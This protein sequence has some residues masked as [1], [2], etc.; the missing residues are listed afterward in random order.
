MIEEKEALLTQL[1]MCVDTDGF[2]NIQS[3][4][5]HGC[6]QHFG[7]VNTNTKLMEWLVNNFGGK[8]PNPRITDNPKWKNGYRW[9]LSGSNSYKLLKKIRQYLLL[10]GEQADCA[11]ELYEKV[12]KLHYG[13]GSG[14]G[15][16]IKPESKKKLQ[17][18]LFQKCKALN[19]TGKSEEEPQLL[20]LIRRTITLEEY[21]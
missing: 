12:S 6:T 17:E 4:E 1:A 15:K 9:S 10:K 19:K 3:S 13:S 5:G 21:V 14:K 20:T 16:R 8:M 2:I 11:I 7:V 18:E